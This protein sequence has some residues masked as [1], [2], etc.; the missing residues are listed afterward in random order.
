MFLLNLDSKPPMYRSEFTVT[1]TVDSTKIKVWRAQ[2]RFE[3]GEVE[4]YKTFFHNKVP[5]NQKLPK[6]LDGEDLQVCRVRDH[7]PVRATSWSSL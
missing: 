3:M 1:A 4:W 6:M 7:P 5:V 2:E